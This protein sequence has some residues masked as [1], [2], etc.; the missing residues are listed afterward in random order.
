MNLFFFCGYRHLKG[1]KKESQS[2]LKE[3]MEKV[4]T[5]I[6]K[7]REK[8]ESLKVEC[9]NCLEK[10]NSSLQFFDIVSNK[11]IA[12]FCS[13]KCWHDFLIKSYS[14][15]KSWNSRII[16][17]DQPK[18]QEES[19][20]ISKI[21]ILYDRININ[22]W[23]Q[24]FGITKDKMYF[25]ENECKDIISNKLSNMECLMLY[26]LWIKLSQQYFDEQIIRYE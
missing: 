18:V 9:G 13:I 11:K 10:K 19:K 5:L 17:D 26:H 25:L 14:T 6:N 7:W 1:T 21:F 15:A 24:L 2:K 12:N 8:V 16:K 4:E 22:D 20:K 3:N 23:E